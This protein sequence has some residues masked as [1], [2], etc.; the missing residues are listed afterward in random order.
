MIGD[1]EIGGDRLL[2][3]RLLLEQDGLLPEQCLLVE[4]A[5]GVVEQPASHAHEREQDEEGLDR[6]DDDLRPRPHRDASGALREQRFLVALERREL[7]DYVRELGSAGLFLL[8]QTRARACIARAEHGIDVTAIPF[9]DGCGDQAE[10]GL[11]RGIVDRETG[12]RIDPTLERGAR[13]TLECEHRAIV[14]DQRAIDA[15]LS[16]VREIQR[17]RRRQL[18][19]SRVHDP[20]SRAAAKAGQHDHRDCQRDHRFDRACGKTSDEL[21]EAL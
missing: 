9:G 14:A 10:L 15:Q 3:G 21:D 16:V 13:R 18:N 4:H 8:R 19:R 12:E 6:D 2:F 20:C 7:Q 5:R 11:L 1:L 17:A